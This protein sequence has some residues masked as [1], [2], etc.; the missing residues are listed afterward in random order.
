MFRFFLAS[1]IICSLCLAVGC[2]SP[3]YRYGIGQATPVAGSSSPDAF[4]I[5]RGGTMPK[6]D[7]FES[8]LD[9]PRRYIRSL[10]GRPEISEEQRQQQLEQ[11]ID[12]AT[13]YLAANEIEDVLI[14]VDVYSPQMQWDR[15]VN[16]Q[17]IAPA[18]KYTGG[19]ANWLR[20]T[21]LPHRVFN[22]NDYDPFTNTLSL[23]SDK[24][25]QGLFESA[26]AKEYRKHELDI[27]VGSYAMLQMVPFVPLV[28]SSK[29][30]ND[31]LTYSEYHLAPELDKQ[32][33]PVVWTRIGSTA[34]SETV[35]VVPGNSFLV[36]GL[37]RLSGA[38]AGRLAGKAIADQK[39]QRLGLAEKS[40]ETSVKPSNYR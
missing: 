9:T 1:S 2:V 15:L 3:E 22:R 35:S 34:V 26:L 5:T 17:Q 36:S 12:I 32:L 4:A 18:W 31:V 21:L 38:F 25:L 40:R 29:A 8:A 33:Y 39:Y 7:R 6:L 19:V 20:Y 28:H 11:S 27:G 37:L 13:E 30:S 10:A 24:P 23:C 16:N 14:D